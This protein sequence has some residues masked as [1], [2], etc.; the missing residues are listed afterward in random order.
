MG[1]INTT[2]RLAKIRSQIEQ[3][4]QVI[5]FLESELQQAIL[6]STTTTIGD[7]TTFVDG[8][9]T[10]AD[11]EQAFKDGVADFGVA[12]TTADQSA[13]RQMLFQAR[14]LLGEL[15]VEEQQW[16]QEVTEEKARRKELTD[17]AKG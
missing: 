7:V 9:Y 12:G 11:L 13:L 14:A 2:A 17:M 10:D 6:G 3:Q 8:V 1:A 5:A 16:N 15:R 4:Q